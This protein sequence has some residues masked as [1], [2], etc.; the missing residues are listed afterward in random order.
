MKR[1]WKRDRDAELDEEIRTHLRMA[2][3]ARVAQGEAR[4]E[5]DLAAR[6]EFGNVTHVKEV[7]RGA[8][9]RLWLEH[10]AQDLRF[11]ARSLRHAPGF[12]AIAV[13]TTALGIGSTTAV[14]TVVNAVL[15]RP[16]PFASADRLV[17]PSYGPRD[18]GSRLSDRQYLELERHASPFSGIATF[19][20][21]PV[22]LTGSGD[23]VRLNSA[24]VTPDFF[25]VLGV[26]PAFGSVF[27]RAPG[28]GSVVLGDAI[29]RSRF[30]ADSSLIGRRVTLDGVPRTVVGIMPAGFTFP[31]RAEIWTPLEVRADPNQSFSRPVV[32][33]LRDDV[34]LEQ[35]RA[36]LAAL[37]TAFEPPAPDDRN[38][39]VV[40]LV[41]LKSLVIGDSRRPL[42]IFSGA[43]ALVLLIACTNVTNLLL[44]RAG[45]RQRELAVRGALGA[46]RSRLLRQLLTEST[47][48]A[49]LGGVAGVLLAI[50]GVRAFLGLAPPEALPRLDSIG[51]NG[52]VL[53][54][55]VALSMITGIGFGVAPAFQATRRSV[56][57]DI[58][59][60]ARTASPS[61]GRMRSLL[62]IAEMALAL[63]LLAGAGLLIRS[64]QRI[65]SVDL[66]FRPAN[67]YTA[68]VEL[69]TASYPDTRAMRAVHGRVLDG[70]ARI[71]GVE[72]AG[73]VNWR[74]L[75][76]MHI[77]GDMR[78]GD[79]RPVPE[80]FLP[81]K[82]AVSP[83]YFPA[84]GIALRRGRAFT[85]QDA[86]NS[87]GVIVISQSIADR[88]W[89]DTDPLGERIS[90][91]DNPEPK[92]WLTIVGI[93]DDVVQEGVTTGAAPALYQPLEQVI[94]PFFLGHMNFVVRSAAAPEIIAPAM[95]A[96]IRDADPNLPVQTIATM[97]RVI[98]STIGDRL[99]QTRLLVFFSIIALV[100]AAIGIYGVTA[101]AVTER[102]HEIGV[103]MALGAHAGDV[104]RMVLGRTVALVIPGVVLGAL[105]A[106]LATRVLSK[107]L[108]GV[109]ADDP[110][111][112]VSVVVL[113]ATVAIVATVGPARRAAR[114]NPVEA[115]KG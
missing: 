37:M 9:G 66:G 18:G 35:A 78:L 59:E 58:A 29:W 81:F 86:A 11:A 102:R 42:L 70:L 57:D 24:S 41:P 68:T 19:S 80:G 87:P 65:R 32:A 7:T 10:L 43:V 88:F 4:A 48:I 6:R 26:S 74:P 17:A 97:D 2:S 109:G 91:E 44:M 16:L 30:A 3:D 40:T 103:R 108:F 85:A 107:L 77:T 90:M 55:A 54:F 53:A 95:R 5:A 110:A 99:F 113:L 49:M 96:A 45:T 82:L 60:G 33:R 8:W 52:P 47:V 62:V 112:F 69:P 36:A 46:S 34:T 71:P 98:L 72:A 111:T 25:R 67:I 39:P 104:V 89:P 31:S 83:D 12:A 114:V 93:V 20:N 64:F 76:S 51:V 100:L 94:R 63:V 79:G 1:F 115:L 21:L 14:F 50:L 101:Y 15:L 13:L 28:D 56:R 38:P 22:T 84:M 61:R 23:P 75:G 106:L 105:G 73:A 27:A 92:D